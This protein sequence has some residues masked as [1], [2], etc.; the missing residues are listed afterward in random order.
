MNKIFS[1]A[2]HSRTT[3][4]N[5]L[6]YTTKT[7]MTVTAILLGSTG[8]ILSF[9][10]QEIAAHANMPGDNTVLFQI[11]GACYFGFA[12]T[13][14]TAKAN[15]IGGIYGR[16]IAIGNFTHFA[17]AGLALIKLTSSHP[18]TIL[19]GVTIIYSSFAIIFGYI[20]FRHPVLQAEHKNE[21]KN[22]GS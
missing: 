18:S 13:N 20:F 12:M 15:L 1:V 8:I 19:T 17:I 2:F 11:L 9:F 10:P 7:I 3:L 5:Q 22:K 21:H 4:T 16:P 14:W 6:M